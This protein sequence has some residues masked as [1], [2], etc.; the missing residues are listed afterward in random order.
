[1]NDI[2]FIEPERYELA[3]DPLYQLGLD[4]DLTRRRFFE[5]VGCGLAVLLLAEEGA[6]QESGFARRGFRGG[7]RPIEIGAWLHIG[8]DGTVTVFTGKAE[9]GQNIRTSLTQAVA[10]ELRDAARHRSAWSWPTRS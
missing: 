10:E 6:A 2:S 9:V 7:Q 4:S 8:E 3:A 1:M 5:L